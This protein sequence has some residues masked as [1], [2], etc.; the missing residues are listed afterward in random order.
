M[1]AYCIDQP[2]QNLLHDEGL[3]IEGARKRLD[4]PED[5]TGDAFQETGSLL[6]DAVAQMPLFNHEE[7]R[8]AQN[9]EVLREIR[10]E[11]LEIKDLLN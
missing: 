1:T 11:L 7:S 5:L 3:T 6:S 4:S 2:D 8:E 9:Q 10:A